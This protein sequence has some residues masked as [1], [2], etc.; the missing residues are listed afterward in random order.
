MIPYT[1]VKNLDVWKKWLKNWVDSGQYTKDIESVIKSAYSI[2]DANLGDPMGAVIFDIDETMISEYSYTNLAG[3]VVGFMPA[4]DFAWT[5]PI[6]DRAQLITTFPAI[7]PVQDF[8]NYCLDKKIKVFVITSKRAKFLKNVMEEF[9]FSKY[10]EPTQLF[11]RPDNDTGSIAQYKYL[12]RMDIVA[13]GYEIVANVGDQP[14][15]FYKG[16]SN[17]NIYIPN[18]FY[19]ITIE[20]VEEHE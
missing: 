15:D 2:V 7:Q 4:N 5:M 11:L 14:S 12:T 17:N 10:R 6:I 19:D 13:N 16:V 8:Y 18:K 3:N 9:N 1:E 20:M